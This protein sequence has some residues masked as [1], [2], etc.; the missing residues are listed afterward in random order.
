MSLS[1]ESLRPVLIDA[2]LS[3]PAARRQY[4][5]QQRSDPRRDELF[6][7]K[8]RAAL[9]GKCQWP[10]GCDMA[11]G[12]L[13]GRDGREKNKCTLDLHHTQYPLDDRKYALGCLRVPWQ[14]D[15]GRLRAWLELALTE[16]DPAC[17]RLLCQKHHG[18]EKK[19]DAA[20][21]HAQR[22]KRQ[23]RDEPDQPRHGQPTLPSPLS[24]PLCAVAAAQPSARCTSA[25]RKISFMKP[26]L[27]SCRQCS[28]HFTWNSSR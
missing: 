5:R 14:Q 7:Q 2:L 13:M 25:M 1:K 17:T 21:P 8:W 16:N 11:A 24:P 28:F 10:D 18:A 9:G 22:M 19:E 15:E 27:P 26:L 4:I 3:L 23:P 6:K 12:K 20:H